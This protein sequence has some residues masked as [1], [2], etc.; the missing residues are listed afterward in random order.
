MRKLYEINSDIERLLDE[1]A[2]IKAEGNGID[3]ETG[4]VFNWEDRLNSLQVEKSEKIKSVITYV[5]NL[6]ALLDHTTEKKKSIEAKETS[7]KKQI[8]G[9][10]KW[11]L[12]ATDNQG[13]A[14]EDIEM[15]VKQTKRCNVVDETLIPPEYFV[16]ITER[17]LSKAAINKAFKAGK[18]V[19]GAE[20]STNYKITIV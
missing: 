10:E 9:L 16:S 6:T 12:Y 2:T 3:V 13:F 11:L 14:D 15:K 18:E 17:K 20:Y 4:E 1:D 8:D 7:L 5:D 19:P